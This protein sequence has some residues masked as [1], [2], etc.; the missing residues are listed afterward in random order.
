MSNLSLED[1]RKAAYRLYGRR[2]PEQT[3]WNDQEDFQELRRAIKLFFSENERSMEHR[4][5][6]MILQHELA[7]SA[8]AETL[9][10]FAQSQGAG[11]EMLD[12]LILELDK[13]MQALR[14]VMEQCAKDYQAYSEDAKSDILG[15]L[16]RLQEISCDD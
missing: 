16:V 8:E 7:H 9:K 6:E 5:R 1:L 11:T 14:Q 15:G 12:L 10:L 13:A 4:F 3:R 2:T